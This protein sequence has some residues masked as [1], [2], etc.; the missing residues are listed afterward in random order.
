MVT[1]P[2]IFVSAVSKELK[3]ARQ[4]VANTLYF[5]G[6]EPVWEDI[7]DAGE[8]DLREMLRKKLDACQ[9]VVH[10]VGQCYGTDLP[11]MDAHFGR[12]SY[13]Q[14][15]A[16][17]AQQQGR[18][19]WR[20]LL[21][22]AFAADPHAPESDDL[23]ALQGAYRERIRSGVLLY[24]PLENSAALEA[25]VLKLRDELGELRRK[26]RQWAALVL[27]LLVALAAGIAWVAMEQKKTN[28][29][30]AEMRQ[31]VD[32]P[33]IGGSEAKLQEDY[34]TALR[35]V[36]KLYSMELPRL[37][38]LLEQN[39]TRTLA[40]PKAAMRDKVNALREAGK[41]VEARD[42]AI[43]SASALEAER[44]RA[45]AQEIQL[46]IEAASSEI[47]FGHYPEA[48]KY[49]DKAVALADRSRDFDSWAA[50]QA[51]LGRIDLKQG[52]AK[53]AEGLDREL[54]R[55]RTAKLGPDH[56]D[57]L[58]S[59]NHLALALDSQGKHAEAEQED[60]AVLGAR[61]RVLGR[62][63]PDTLISRNN[64]ASALYAQGK[65]AEA[66]QEFRVVL[67]THV[68]VLSKEHPDALL[69]RN[70]LASVLNSQGKYT[71]AENEYRTVLA[72]Q[73][74]VLGPEHPDTF[75]SCYNLATCLKNQA[76]PKEALE[77]AQRA[78]EGWKRTL[79][80]DHPNYQEAVKLCAQ[81]KA[82][83]ATEPL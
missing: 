43:K 45:S 38:A 6:Y 23:R 62:D 29:A 57:V 21:D 67:A 34:E 17:Y 72:A 54:V 44:Q 30:L 35:L 77:F 14:Y 61:E 53:E 12:V 80:V 18:K 83:V 46:W 8:G 25:N 81:L 49:T 24:H 56:P 51:A 47:A 36:A 5:L 69:S 50:A 39:A 4:L 66:E 64:L 59:R 3:S 27:A 9:G 68:R 71:E 52:H 73:E 76:R 28:A 58:M 60:R 2:V 70:N 31:R 20:L 11:V 19:V 41:F 55:M 74:R 78:R 79:G 26:S 1:R 82:A 65:Y 32:S 33:A 42:F 63:N 15:E 16:L 37:R 13:T 40:D 7:F 22:D 10:L 48:R 75:L